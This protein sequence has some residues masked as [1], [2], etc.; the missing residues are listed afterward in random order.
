M[1]E[2]NADI[3]NVVVAQ[4]FATPTAM[5]PVDYK[6][7][8]HPVAIRSTACI[9]NRF[10]IADHLDRKEN[11]FARISLIAVEMCVH[12][13]WC[14]PQDTTPRAVLAPNN[15]KLRQNLTEMEQ[16]DGQF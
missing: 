4:S 14:I 7:L 1:Y 13:V 3:S 11:R 8:K 2:Q 9:V 5:S 10:R 16:K 6:R 12:C 15:V